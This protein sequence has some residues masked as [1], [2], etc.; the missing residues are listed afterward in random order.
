MFWTNKFKSCL[1]LWDFVMI[2]DMS[3]V[4]KTYHGLFYNV[5]TIKE[6]FLCSYDWKFHWDEVS[7]NRFQSFLTK[8]QTFKFKFSEGFQWTSLSVL[9]FDKQV[10]KLFTSVRFSNVRKH[11]YIFQDKFKVLLC[12][13]KSCLPMYKYRLLI[14]IFDNYLLI[15][16]NCS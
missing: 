3:K 1:P 6:K 2:G 5:I 8:F 14:T 10:Q 12:K 15:T 7:W 13:F 11:R 9:Q 4:F 16:R